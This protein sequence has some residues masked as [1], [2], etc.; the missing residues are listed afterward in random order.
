MYSACQS[1]QSISIQPKPLNGNTLEVHQGQNITLECTVIGVESKREQHWEFVSNEGVSMIFDGE[2]EQ[3]SVEHCT[4]T[5]ELGITEASMNISGKYTCVYDNG[6]NSSIQLVFI[7][8]K[9]DL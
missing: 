1:D 5:A 9:L 6:L 3:F 7:Q 2:N 4:Q 8:G